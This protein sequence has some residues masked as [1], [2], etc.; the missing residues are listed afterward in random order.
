MAAGDDAV[1]W[2]ALQWL[3]GVLGTVFLLLWAVLMR[4]IGLKG[5]MEVQNEIKKT[6]DD[7]VENS[8][9]KTALAAH[10]IDDQ[11]EFDKTN[12]HIHEVEQRAEK[13]VKELAERLERR[14]ERSEDRII[15][16]IKKNG[17]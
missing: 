2:P 11:E 14:L 1:T 8:V 5:T 12:L 16:A 4:M 9:T 10:F 6:V 17:H 15:E 3:L 13:G 7:L